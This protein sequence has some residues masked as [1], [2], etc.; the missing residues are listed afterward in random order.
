MVGTLFLVVGPSGAGKDSLLN[1]A[2]RHFHISAMMVFPKRCITRPS[3]TRSSDE[4]AGGRESHIAVT[5]AQFRDM[6]QNGA[7]AFSW[8]AHGLFYGIPK[9]IDTDL[10]TGRH[11]VVNVSRAVLSDISQRY[12][13]ICILSVQVS[14]AVLYQR[15]K[16]RGRETEAEIQKRLARA[17]AYSYTGDNVIDIDNSHDVEVAAQHFI[18]TIEKQIALS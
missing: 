5:P 14:P 16:A 17:S 13:K 1:A 18:E 11:V 12:A 10:A 3:E 7:F 9:A 2:Q 8:A 6:Q 15:L 4:M